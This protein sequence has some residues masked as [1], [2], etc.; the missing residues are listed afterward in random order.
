MEKE[1]YLDGLRG[2]AAFIVVVSHF[3]IGFYPSFHTGNIDTLRTNSGIEILF[4]K[5]PLNLIYG[6]NVSVCIFFI[7][8]AYV[9][10]YRF[11][12]DNNENI[13]ISSLVRRYLRLMPPVLFSITVA[14]CLMKLGLFYN[15]EA[16][17]VTLSDWWL[18]S[19]YN[20]EPNFYEMIKQ[21]LY[22]VFLEHSYTYNSVLWTM[23]Y[24]FYGSLIV[25]V[26]ALVFGKIKNRYIF[27]V[28]ALLITVKTYF[29]TF[30]LGLILSD[31]SNSKNNFTIRY[32]KN[33]I[34]IIF[35]IIGLFLASYPPGIEVE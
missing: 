17:K 28:V 11:F 27:Y 3:L 7:L 20:F 23:Y 12:R 2:L 4:A 1:K 10:T 22:G 13:I 9:L 15:V 16:S 35:I 5:T 21:G 25:L 19:F 18:G 26:S 8:S 32:N 31:L 14:Y 24:E 34:N 6:G 33:Y 29:F 30:F